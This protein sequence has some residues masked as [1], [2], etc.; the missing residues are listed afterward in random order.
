MRWLSDRFVQTAQESPLAGD[1]PKEK[2]PEVLRLVATGKDAVLRL[3]NSKN[4]VI[5]ITECEMPMYM[6]KART[7]LQDNAPECK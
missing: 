1:I 7:Y 3:L 4:E 2:I 6:R 5:E